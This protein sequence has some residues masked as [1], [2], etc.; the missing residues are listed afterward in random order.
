MRPSRWLVVGLLIGAIGVVGI[1]G[2]QAADPQL[3]DDD[4]SPLDENASATLWSRYAKDCVEEERAAELTRMQELAACTDVTFKE[5]PRTASVW[6][7]AKHDDLEPGDEDLS[8]YPENTTTEDAGVIRDA[9]T[10]IFAIQPST[11]AHRDAAG[12]A[13][14]VSPNGAVRGL[15]DYRI[16]RPTSS[17]NETRYRWT[18]VSHNVTEVRLYRDETRLATQPGSQRPRVSYRTVGSGSATL[19]LEADIEAQLTG[20]LITNGTDENRTRVVRT[21]NVT[22]SDSAPVTVYDLEASLY[23]TTYPD[24]DAAVAVYQQEPYHGYEL[25]EQRRAI[26]RGIWRYYTARDLDWDRLVRSTAE[27]SDVVESMARPVYVHAFP[28]QIGP[29]AE[30]I[31]G[32]PQLTQAWGTDSPSPAAGL[33]ENVT[34]GIVNGSYRRTHGLSLR[35]DSFSP[36]GVTVRGIVRGVNASVESTNDSRRSIRESN[37]TATVLRTTDSSMTVRLELRDASTGTP[38]WLEREPGDGISKPENRGYIEIDGQRV[39]T[40]ASGVAVV[41]VGP[42]GIYTARYVPRSWRVVD[43]AYVGDTATVRQHPL[44]SIDGLLSLGMSVLWLFLPFGLAFY[45]G[46]RLSRFI[47]IPE[48]KL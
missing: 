9:H 22:V 43:P 36:D 44:L 17:E 42:T 7:T 24:G 39:R 26:L 38:I 34:V 37:L 35:H 28:A 2:A 8:V 10:T 12:P 27:G 18:N 31:R 23:H 16:R 5:P 41:T 33:H 4:A 45:A 13:H 19:R 14:Y 25:D 15:V 6:T 32:H 20:W 11:Y 48:S 40:N 21:S 46:L 3:P 29:R 30:P 1:D 47:D